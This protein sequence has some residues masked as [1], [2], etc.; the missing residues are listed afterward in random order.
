MFDLFVLPFTAGL[1]FLLVFISWKFIS[2]V[3]ALS[4]DDRK[5]VAKSVFTRSSLISVK[6][7]MMESLLH[8]KIFKVNPRLGYMHMSLA[9]GWLLLILAGN[10]E[11][12]LFHHG[13]MSAPYVPIFFRFFHPNP[14]TFEFHKSFSVLMDLLLLFVLSGVALAYYKRLNSK[15]L[16][17]KKTTKL[18]QGDRIALTALWF[19]FPLRL[20]AESF[21]SGTFG[22]GSFITN[23]LGNFLVNFLPS[24][25]LYYAFWWAYSFSLGAFFVALPFSRYMHI[26]TETLLIFLRNAGV[27][28]TAVHTGF[29]DVE[30]N[31]CSRCGICIDTCQLSSA[32]AINNI[33]SVYQ[34]RD[35]RY[36]M[37]EADKS[38][39][40]LMCGRCDQT[41]PVGIDI[42]GIRQ[43]KR[44]ELNPGL[45]ED[46]GYIKTS[47]SHYA[48]VIYFAGCMS[49]LT[50]SIKKSVVDAFKKSGVNFWFMDEHESICCGRPLMLAGK[51]DEAQAMMYKNKTIIEGSNGKA[52]VT[53][54]PIC[55]KMFNEQ[56]Q[57]K[58]PVYHH[59]QYF[60]GMMEN[61]LMK[62]KKHN[63]KAV[64]HDPCELGRG[65]KVYED[66][67]EVLNGALTLVQADQE[68]ENGLCCGGS[69]GNTSISMG[70]RNKITREACDI[71]LKNQ[72]DILVTSCPLCKKTF[73]KVSDVPVYDIAE[74]V[75]GSIIIKKGRSDLH[76]RQETSISEEIIENRRC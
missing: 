1:A 10:L 5:K 66:P 61:N 30:L 20:L 64:Y 35:I 36:N 55:Y 48:D 17:L 41:C 75:N 38:L 21:T 2:W 32:A 7:I 13:E 34:L 73:Q 72:P 45:R 11:S 52:L 19:I 27:K 76:S 71:L 22:G 44:S 9:F 33:Q 54:C 29:T 49:H 31:A 74:I 58:I 69:L 26:P 43:I 56:Y 40:C 60:A 8:R 24:E 6:E 47:A 70:D 39:N 3:K 25:S 14:V 62:L 15:F 23:T 12:R 68:R 42:T 16:G 28:E 67:R 51:K 18:V 59:S 4:E 37:V 46:F 53:N 50:P 63:I 57:L 65:S